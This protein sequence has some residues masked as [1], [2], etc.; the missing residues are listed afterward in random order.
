[1]TALLEIWENFLIAERMKRLV[2]Q[3]SFASSWFW[4]TRQ[5]LEIDYLEEED[6]MLRSY[7]FKWNTRK[8]G[9]KC[10]ESF[11]LAY[12]N[13]TFQVITPENIEEWL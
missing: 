3:Q 2:Y 5:Q 12:P 8:A 13:A 6:G 10:P 1:M 4:R 11:R 9:V 7:E